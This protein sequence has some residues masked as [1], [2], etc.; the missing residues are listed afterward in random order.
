MAS[1][2]LSRKLKPSPNLAEVVGSPEPMSRA[3]AV[4]RIWDHIKAHDLQ[5]PKNRREI[6]ADE[7]LQALAGKSRFSMFEVGK[8][9][10][11]NLSDSSA[12][13][14]PKKKAA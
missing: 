7:K 11:E 10:N 9:V 6:L 2:A 13:P 3:E 8:I 1:N 4:Q 14:A 5:D 12:L